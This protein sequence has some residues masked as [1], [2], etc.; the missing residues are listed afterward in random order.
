MSTALVLV[1]L[2]TLVSCDQLHQSRPAIGIFSTPTPS[3]LASYGETI[4]P[5]SYVKWLEQ[6]GHR[7]V[8]L[9][10]DIDPDDLS[11]VLSSL[12]GFILPGGWGKPTLSPDTEEDKRQL[13]AMAQVYHYAMASNKAG[14][15]FPLWGTCLGF[16]I[17]ALLATGREVLTETNSQSSID[18][19]WTADT[20]T[21]RMLGDLPDDVAVGALKHNVTA[22]YHHYGVLPADF[23]AHA[24]GDWRVV[25]TQTDRDGLEYVAAFEHRDFPIFAVQWHPERAGFEAKPKFDSNE[26]QLVSLR[27]SQHLSMVL[28]KHSRESSVEY[29]LGPSY[30]SYS[31][32]EV[33]L[34][35]PQDFPFESVYVL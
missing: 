12:N 20:T 28:G 27:L 22:N 24:G 29:D 6:S 19:L 35:S 9:R 7:I 3:H 10:Y 11:G 5:G 8:M 32:R 31:H 34:Q 30:L 4:I 2:I 17:M 15:P 13:A 25:V 33:W 21:S 1:L 16:E 18:P 14:A 23:E 26:A